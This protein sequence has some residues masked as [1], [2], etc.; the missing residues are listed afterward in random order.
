[1]IV[2]RIV[3]KVDGNLEATLM[4]T[5]EQAAFLMNM[6][7]GLLVQRGAATLM[8]FDSQEE[9]DEHKQNEQAAQAETPAP[10]EQPVPPSPAQ[11]K[12]EAQMRFL[13]A[14]DVE[15]LPKA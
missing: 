6:G 15:L 3:K 9:Y 14:V 10:I 5:G 12:E 2:K 1:M 8:D 11:A 13:E 4:L 7:L